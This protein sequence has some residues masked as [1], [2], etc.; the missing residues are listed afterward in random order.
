MNFYEPD[1]SQIDMMVNSF[2]KEKIAY[3]EHKLGVKDLVIIG[4]RPIDEAIF[5]MEAVLNFEYGKFQDSTLKYDYSEKIEFTVETK[6]YDE[7]GKI[8]LVGN[9]L[10]DKYFEVENFSNTFENGK[11]LLFT[12][13]SFEKVVNNLAYFS[14]T[15]TIGNTAGNTFTGSLS[16]FHFDS[17]QQSVKAVFN[18]Y[19]NNSNYTLCGI[20]L[21]NS[22]IFVPN[23]FNPNS[24][25]FI[26]HNG[27]DL[28]FSNFTN[29]L[30]G[31]YYID[32]ESWDDD[33]IYGWGRWGVDKHLIYYNLQHQGDCFDY[34]NLNHYLDGARYI[35]QVKLNALPNNRT[36]VSW[37]LNYG[38]GTI[39]DIYGNPTYVCWS[40]IVPVYATY[41]CSSLP[42]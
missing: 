18:N 12:D 33:P 4:D 1:V 36:I 30:D 6:G 7:K 37:N 2:Q 25:S 5:L 31:S 42:Y 27:G 41:Y 32:Y 26:C 39:H 16:N 23:N 10:M 29:P 34:N 17:T 9:D 35:Y 38:T 22:K 24:P 15:K 20:D 3:Q 21:I 14:S 8:L 13:I 28:I 40:W 19:C 11:S